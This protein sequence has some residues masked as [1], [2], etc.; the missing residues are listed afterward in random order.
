[1]SNMFPNGKLLLKCKPIQYGPLIDSGITGADKLIIILTPNHHFYICSHLHD[2]Y[3]LHR[4]S[5]QDANRTGFPLPMNKT[6]ELAAMAIP[7]HP[8]PLVLQLMERLDIIE[9]DM[10]KLYLVYERQSH[11]VTVRM[12]GSGCKESI[13]GTLLLRQQG[14]VFPNYTSVGLDVEQVDRVV[15]GLDEQGEGLSLAY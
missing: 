14:E 4:N 7:K 15:F 11:T 12:D 3:L 1:M 6:K 2:T 8:H 13:K 10:V 5:I 9:Q